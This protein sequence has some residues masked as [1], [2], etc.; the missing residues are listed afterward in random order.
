MHFTLKGVLDRP[1][2]MGISG[3]EFD[4]RVHAGRDG[5]V[6][7]T[8]PE[9]LALEQ[10]RFKHAL[11][12]LDHEG[13]GHA[14]SDAISL[15]SE[16]D[17]RLRVVWGNRAKAIVIEPE[18]EAWIWGANNVLQEVFEWPLS[19]PIREWLR[20][21]DFKIDD[22]GKPVRP[23]EALEEIIQIHRKPR[24]SALYFRIASKISLRRCEDP[25]FLRLTKQLKAW[26]PP[27]IED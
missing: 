9:T 11:L 24:S 22:R 25:A 1:A 8:G 19:I 27:K 21:R 14:A 3:I 15:E 6:R 23:K 20:E 26:F 17:E 18:L 13:S 16:L 5:G 12:V 10:K 7:A 4:F 2:A